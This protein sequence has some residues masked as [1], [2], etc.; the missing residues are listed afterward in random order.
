MS[1]LGV[2]PGEWALDAA[3]KGDGSPLRATV[4]VQ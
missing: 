2:E 3:V 1:E 4:R